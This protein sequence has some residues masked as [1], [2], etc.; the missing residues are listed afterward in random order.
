MA[1]DPESTST[2]RKRTAKAAKE[3]TV[4]DKKAATSIQKETTTTANAANKSDTDESPNKAKA[5][6]PPSH[7]VLTERDILP[8]LW[9]PLEREGSYSK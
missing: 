5:K 4:T 2:K 9:T 1:D 6:K 7:Q 8:K 3:V